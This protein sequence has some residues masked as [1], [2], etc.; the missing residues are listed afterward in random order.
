MKHKS[1]TIAALLGLGT[2]GLSAQTKATTIYPSNAPFQKEFGVSM[3]MAGNNNMVIGSEFELNNG[4]V[5]L[6]QGA[7]FKNKING[8]DV[9]PNCSNFGLGTALDQTW[10]V[11]GAPTSSS[12]SK[13]KVFLFKDNS[14][15]YNFGTTPVQVL[16][17]GTLG[18][19]FGNAVAIEGDWL[20]VGARI[21]G[22][23]YIYKRTGTGATSWTLKD[24]LTKV[25]NFGNAVAMNGNRL[26]VGAD[27]P[28]GTGNVYIYE[29]NA[30]E[31]YVLTYDRSLNGRPS[32]ATSSYGIDVDITSS[33]IIVGDRLALKAEILTGGGSSW[34]QNSVLNSPV[35]THGEFGY[36]VAIQYNRAVVGAPFEF[37]KGNV[38]LY[39]QLN[40]VYTLQ[41]PL[42]IDET[43]LRI[44]KFGGAVDI[45]FDDY[46]GATASNS[47]YANMSGDDK[48]V[49]FNVNFSNGIQSCGN[50]YESNNSTAT[51][52]TMAL[53]SAVEAC[54]NSSTDKDYYKLVL[55]TADNISVTLENLV[56]DY[57]FQ[58][59]NSSG[60]ILYQTTTT[61]SA[62]EIVP[63]AALAAG[64]Y[65]IYVYGQGGANSG[66]R[67][68]L[69]AKSNIC[70][71]AIFE[72]NNTSATAKLIP[73][74]GQNNSR[75]YYGGI[76]TTGDEDWYSF[77]TF[78]SGTYVYNNIKIGLSELTND[79]D[80]KLY[81][82]SLVEIGSSTFG[83]STSEQ[84]ISNGTAI[85]R[86]YVKVYG[87]AGATSTQCYNLKID[88]DYAPLARIETAAA[89]DKAAEVTSLMVF[90]SPAI[91]GSSV[92]INVA[93]GLEVAK[94][95]VMN[96][97]GT[98]VSE[99]TLKVSNQSATLDLSTVQP[100][101]YLI[102]AA[103]AGKTKL[104]VE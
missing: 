81:N 12:V 24:S 34:T 17:G 30:S 63:S 77:D 37:G 90:P 67:Y 38:Y 65:Y 103:E 15:N 57:N 72:P 41:N 54:I 100:G 64:T 86:H 10:L 51:A 60:T 49:A 93:Q 66:T 1:F 36:A 75:N 13:G 92:Q 82:S 53:N 101:M 52:T 4:A 46:V 74:M 20:A 84:I 8:K 97:N 104:V 99:Q 55:P 69:T 102:D 48:G 50:T 94:V 68:K 71:D 25:G 21:T 22:K 44:H 6:Y 62:T 89:T 29:R 23:V 88:L 14:S 91:A 85:G 58:I 16:T 9:D 26:V 70:N 35:G 19:R 87:W 32:W 98:V 96:L 78:T 80:V 47:G 43:N 28:S 79:F 18:G 83:G 3:A 76:V 42:I 40:N 31:K 56:V 95:R 7:T 27:N 45:S 61:G 39:T 5:Y 11:A 33:A 59:L 2:L 73:N